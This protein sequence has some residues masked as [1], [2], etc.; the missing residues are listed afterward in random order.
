MWIERLE[1]KKRFELNIY[2]YMRRAICSIP[3][4]VH[5]SISLWWSLHLITKLCRAIEICAHT[6]VIQPTMLVHTGAYWEKTSSPWRFNLWYKPLQLRLHASPMMLQGCTFK[7]VAWAAN[8]WWCQNEHCL[9]Y[10]FTKPILIIILG[11][12]NITVCIYA[13]SN[14]ETDWI[15]Y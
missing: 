11:Y 15:C 9:T 12:C 14:E 8:I 10:R 1:M 5:Y 13:Y 3:C 2:I 4:H 7:T 6:F